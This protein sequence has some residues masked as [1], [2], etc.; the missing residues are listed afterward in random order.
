M[1]GKNPNKKSKLFKI[2]RAIFIIAVLV[3]ISMYFPVSYFIISPGSAI[4]V[5]TLV[6]VEDSYDEN[7]DFMLTTVSMYYA[8]FASYIYSKFN[9][10]MN[11]VPKEYI[12]AEGEKQE[13]Y[14]DRQIYVMDESQEKA[15][16]AAFRYL[17]L[18]LEIKEN[19]LIIT[20][21]SNDSPSKDVLE[22]GDKI[23]SVDNHPI[24]KLDE[25]LNLLEGKKENEVVNVEFLRDSEVFSKDIALYDLN[26]GNIDAENLESRVGIG[27]FTYEDW[28]IITSKNIKFNS[29]DIGGPSAG[30]MFTLEI[31]NQLTPEDLTKGYRVAGTGTINEDGVVGQIGSA[32]MKVKAANEEDADFFFVPKDI[33]EGDENEKNAIQSNEDL[34]NPLNIIPVANLAE[35]VEYLQNLPEK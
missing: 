3:L 4:E 7:G 24:N 23:I 25:L 22:V 5:D 14:A 30:L 27:I 19:G 13:D 18:P 1:R 21:I 8:S 2:Q 16:I 15:I 34:G 11:A 35:A 6:E 12:L 20:G 26:E 32:R 10:F 28:D 31:I 29:E 33:V 9:S 17:D